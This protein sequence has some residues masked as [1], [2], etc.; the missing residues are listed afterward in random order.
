M[1]NSKKAEE[2]KYNWQL[3]IIIYILWCIPVE[4][5]SKIVIIVYMKLVV[6]VWKTGNEMKI[7]CH[8][9]THFQLFTLGLT[10][11]KCQHW[12]HLKWI[13][14]TL[15]NGHRLMMTM[16]R[17]SVTSCPLWCWQDDVQK[18]F[19]LSCNVLI[20]KNITLHQ[21]IR[22]DNDCLCWYLYTR[23]SRQS[24]TVKLS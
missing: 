14:Q 3:C 7:T 19:S 5:V 11:I 24:W 8:I 23:Y 16:K 12:P 4:L 21:S 15:I 22:D 9:I 13:A 20:R 1:Y 6:L 10:C 17:N 18:P 2:G